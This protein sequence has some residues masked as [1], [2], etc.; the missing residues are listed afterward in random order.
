MTYDIKTRCD[1]LQ[2]VY[3]GHQCVV[4]KAKQVKQ[5]ESDLE[6]AYEELLKQK[7]ESGED[8]NKFMLTKADQVETLFEGAQYEVT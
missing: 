5:T 7:P 2:A 1:S 8:G 3:N 4:S 6:K